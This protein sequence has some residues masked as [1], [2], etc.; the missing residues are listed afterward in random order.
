VKHKTDRGKQKTPAAAWHAFVEAEGK[1]GSKLGEILKESVF[2]DYVDGILKLYFSDKTLGKKARG[3]IEKLKK[4]LPP[5]LLPCNKLDC[6]EDLIPTTRRPPPASD[7][8][9]PKSLKVE[10]VNNP[11]QA[12]NLEP[13]GRGRKEEELP[14]P[15]LEKAAE[16][17]QTCQPIYDQLKQRTELLVGPAGITFT[18]A[19][20]WRLRVGGTRGF[21]EL[22]L[23][24]FHP[25]FGIPYIPASTLKGATLAWARTHKVA[26]DNILNDLFGILDGR[27][28]KAAKVEFLDAFPTQPCLSVDVATPQWHWKN[29]QVEYKPE[30][31]PL[32]SLKQ[33][34]I[35]IGLRPATMGT[36]D[37]VQKVKT[38]LEEALK[39]GIGSRIS[40][41]YGRALGQTPQFLHS[42]SYNFE[43]WTQ[44]M[45]GSNPKQ[46]EFRATAIR[47]LLRYWFRAVALSFYSPTVCQT[48]ED[49]IF[50]KLSQWGQLSLSALCSPPTRTAP[51]LYE[52]KIILE[53]R[54]KKVLHLAGMLLKLSAHLG[55]VGRGSRRPLHIVNSWLRGC[56]W[57]ID[58]AGMPL[59]YEVEVWQR[60]FKQLR[61]AFEAVQ[62]PLGS[63]TCDPGQRKP[64][65]QDVLDRHAQ[66]WLV[67][68]RDQLH[69][70][71]VE[72]WKLSGDNPDVRGAA[73]NLLY[74]DDHFKGE[75]KDKNGQ[76]SG[77][78]NVGGA[79]GT[80]SF[81][82]IKSIFPDNASPYQVVTIFGISVDQKARLHFAK[83]LN[84]LKQ[85]GRAKLVF[86]AMP[87]Q[88]S[89]Q[90]PQPPVRKR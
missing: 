18:V 60:F 25:V 57:S 20:Q 28:A 15:I 75:S 43:L 51:D 56:H 27:V 35:L 69:P 73:L 87:A 42:Q 66:V 40:S 67:Q 83:T 26:E 21:R 85:Q 8:Q 29:D 89:N 82:W 10:E 72:D 31:H 23:P 88:G 78:V 7:T 55:G 70:D 36:A 12:L 37:D 16:A 65:K 11:L 54:D 74:G 76:T 39:T 53:A 52:G 63:Y 34:K 81:V 77:N 33:P 45:Y 30:P 17:E 48:L 50:G 64:R 5:E 13:F 38:W 4:K 47:G 14:Q 19:F 86:G 22:L 61:Q 62:R 1:T 9:K 84:Q 32:L 41:G 71:Q 80:P 68:S 49:Q 59:G 79:L 3:Q 44:G 46:S 24:A 90:R 58:D 2:V 6:L